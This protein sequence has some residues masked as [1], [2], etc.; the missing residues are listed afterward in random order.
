VT[1]L[2]VPASNPRWRGE[3]TERRRNSIPS[4][5]IPKPDRS[6]EGEKPH[7]PRSL[8]CRRCGVWRNSTIKCCPPKTQRA[9][10]FLLRPQGTRTDCG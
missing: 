6:I 8:Q 3:W 9:Q 1:G 5:V 4:K 7:Y 2:K 10:D